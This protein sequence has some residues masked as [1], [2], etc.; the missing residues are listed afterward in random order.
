MS[1][2]WA[3]IETSLGVVRIEAGLAQ[4]G[5][6]LGLVA[7]APRRRPSCPSGPR[8]C[9]MFLSLNET[10]RVG[11]RWNTWPMTT[12]SA[13][14]SRGASIRGTQL[15][16]NS[17]WPPATTVAGTIST[18]PGQDRD[19]EAL[20]AVV[21][22]VH[23]REVA[24]ELGLREPLELEPDRLE[25]AGALALA[26][27]LGRGTRRP[28]G[29]SR[30][31]ITGDTRNAARRHARASHHGIP[32]IASDRGREPVRLLGSQSSERG[33]RRGWRIRPRARTAQAH[34][35]RLAGRARA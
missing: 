17:A 7:E 5:I 31:P 11:E 20:V 18:A 25:S 26:D 32:L 21:A 3:M 27:A 28:L 14:D 34:S 15:M 1:N 22:L 30:G 35:R 23:R 8:A 4:P 2:C 6:Q 16:P 12:P 19:V 33:V 24:G 13:P 29:P 9:V 10:W